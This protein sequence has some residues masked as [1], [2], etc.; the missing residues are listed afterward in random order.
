MIFSILR[1]VLAAVSV[2][3]PEHFNADLDPT[4]HADADPAL[5]PDQFLFS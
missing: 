4:F 3:D 2:A 5:D 1:P